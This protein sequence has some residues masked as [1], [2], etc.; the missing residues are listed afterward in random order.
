MTCIT[1]HDPHNPVAPAERADRYR[2]VCLTCHA[3]R[4]CRLTVA[5]RQKQAGDDCTRCHMPRGDTEVPHLAFTHHRIG[6]HPLT[7]VLDDTDAGL[8]PVPLSDLSGLNDS[9]RERSLMLGRL[10]MLLKRGPEFQ[11]SPAGSELGRRIDGWLRNERPDDTDA[12]LE[13]NRFQFLQSRGDWNG[14]MQSAARA[15]ACAGL[16]SEEEAAILEHLGVY[17]YS[18]DQMEDARRRFAQ[19]TR[20]RSNGY[21]WLLLGICERK[22]GRPQAAIRA[23]ERARE[24]E[25][26]T[27]QVYEA[28]AA[29][30]QAQNEPE[31]RERVLEDIARLKRK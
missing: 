22:L 23:L 11:Q 24:F 2:S 26:A 28:L 25:P 4:G 8:S 13:F 14:A 16:R 29:A 3:D 27:I 1:C 9:E 5:D 7:E 31:R 15:L 21:D 30:Y 17:E 19:L 12:E 20:L 6:I 18:Q 10:Q